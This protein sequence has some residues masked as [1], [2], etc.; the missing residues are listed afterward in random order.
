ML[1]TAGH[2]LRTPSPGRCDSPTS[3]HP[4]AWQPCEEGPRCADCPDP[5]WASFRSLGKNFG[6][7]ECCRGNDIQCNA[8]T[9]VAT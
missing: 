2:D 4:P 1:G 3:A 7:Q 6:G 9:G 5:S 8:A